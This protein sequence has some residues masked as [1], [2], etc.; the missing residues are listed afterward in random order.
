VRAQGGIIG[1]I[2]AV[3]GSSDIGQAIINK[4]RDAIDSI[5]V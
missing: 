2:I 5:G 1:A 4:I 3:A